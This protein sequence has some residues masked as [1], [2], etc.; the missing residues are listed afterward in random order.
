MSGTDE[1]ESIWSR[2]FNS[3]AQRPISGQWPLF[4][5]NLE[6][7][8]SEKDQA[9]FKGSDSTVH[10][11]ECYSKAGEI[12]ELSRVVTSFKT[13]EISSKQKETRLKL[14]IEGHKSFI[15]I[16]PEFISNVIHKRATIFDH[17]NIAD[18]S[19]YFENIG[20]KIRQVVE[21]QTKLLVESNDRRHVEERLKL[22]EN[23]LEEIADLERKNQ[24]LR[25]LNQQQKI[26]P[27]AEARIMESKRI[28][29]RKTRENAFLRKKIAELEDEVSIA[30]AEERIRE[31][32]HI[33]EA[34]FCIESKSQKSD[35]TII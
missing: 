22:K 4:I 30:D 28:I 25:E 18:E 34:S 20:T 15:Q 10:C 32:L 23:Y 2:N 11:K 12:E 1:V 3:E 13:C 6:M 24:V 14:S 19:Q 8:F 27:N 5:D 35:N 9:S 17:T 21:T 29:L 33:G 16:I 7:Q 31:A 26:D